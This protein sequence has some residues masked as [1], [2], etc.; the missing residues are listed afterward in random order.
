[1]CVALHKPQQGMPSA[2]IPIIQSQPNGQWVLTSQFHGC[3]AGIPSNFHGIR[4]SRE[5]C[6]LDAWGLIFLHHYGV[7]L[8]NSG[9]TYQMMVNRL[10]K[11]LLGITMEAYIDNMLVKSKHQ[12]LHP[13]DLR[14]CFEIMDMLNLRFNS[15]KCTFVVRTDKFLAFM[16]WIKRVKTRAFRGSPKNI[17]KFDDEI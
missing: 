4:G 1:M 14:R 15:K 2:P 3:I 11:D 9:V 12:N 8:R 16:I 6:I 7:H 10:F 13:K 17:L 5:N